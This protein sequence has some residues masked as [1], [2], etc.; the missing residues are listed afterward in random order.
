M[1]KKNP[2][3]VALGRKGGL[4]RTPAKLEAAR[5]A[6]RFAGRKPKFAIGDPVRANE[7]AP[8]TYRDRIGT[9]A[10]IGPAKSEYR[11]EFTDDPTCPYGYLMSWWLDA[12]DSAAMPRDRK[13]TSS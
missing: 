9:V 3:A 7:H 1:T 4:A 6:A 2:H 5:N 12:H 8:A 11:V 13:K 10:Q